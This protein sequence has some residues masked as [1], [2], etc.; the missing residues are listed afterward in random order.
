MELA[1]VTA[2]GQVTI[3]IEIRK[4]LGIKNGDKILFVE[5]SGR[6]YMMNSSMDALREAQRAF[7]GEAERLGLKDDDV[8]TMIKELRGRKCG[9]VNEKLCLIPCVDISIAISRCKDGCN[10]ELYIYTPSACVVIV[11][12]R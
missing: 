10:D 7:A 5:E 8:M 12:C 2:K 1:K 4:K 9:E 11:C 3:P 6:I